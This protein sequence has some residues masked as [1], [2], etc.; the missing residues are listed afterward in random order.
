MCKSNQQPE[1]LNNMVTPTRV[2][3]AQRRSPQGQQQ[4]PNTNNNNNNG[5]KG[6]QKQRQQQQQLKRVKSQPSTPTGHQQQQNRRRT[7]PMVHQRSTPIHIQNNYSP[8]STQNNSPRSSPSCF[9]GS[10]CFEPPTPESLPK[11]PSNWTPLK[12]TNTHHVRKALN[13]DEQDL[14]DEGIKQLKLL[15]KVQA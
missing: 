5:S 15:L 11:P 6:G 14:Q 10:K 9:A 2:K 8:L 1:H 7:P 13:F 3:P 12:D 4:A